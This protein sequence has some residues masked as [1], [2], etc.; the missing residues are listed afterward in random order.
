MF[1]ND[2]FVESFAQIDEIAAKVRLDVDFAFVQAKTSKHLN[3]AEIGS[4]IQ[5]VREFFSHRDYKGSG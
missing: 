1:V 4:F 5:G 2:V 3:A